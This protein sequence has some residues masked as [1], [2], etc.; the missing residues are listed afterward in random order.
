M[1]EWHII[2]CEYPPQVGGVS[3]YTYMLASALAAAGDRLHMWC[4]AGSG[5]PPP[6]PGLIV[7]RELGE[8]TP[9]DLHRVGKKLDEFSAPRR[10]LVQ[11]VPHGYGYQSMNLYFCT[12]LWSRVALHHDRVEIMVHEPFLPFSRESLKQTAAAVVHRVMTLVLLH[13]ACRVWV[14]IPAWEVCLRPYALGR[15]LTWAWLPVP[16]SVPEVAD[17][18]GVA[19]VRAAHAPPQ[20]FLVGHFGAYAGS[21][22]ELL[23]AFVAEL[24]RRNPAGAVLLLGRGSVAQRDELLR[25][26]P[27]LAGQVHATGVLAAAD[28]SRHLRACDVLIQPYPD[29]VSS[30]RTSVMAGLSHGLPIVTTVGDLTEALWA[31]SGAV[32]L[33]PAGD[34]TTMVKLTERLLRDK[35][36][37]NRLTAAAKALHEHRFALGHTVATLRAPDG[38][39]QP[40]LRDIWRTVL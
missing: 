32:A 19:L 17:S 35:T 20:G 7:H 12:W 3:D 2:T 5:D 13:A 37:R 11:W 26:H 30:R 23:T 38:C 14:A 25:R 10:L 29:G 36:E 24:L 1:A 4:P 28:I 16:G 21:I 18:K 34:V 6:A 22:R 31:E 9:G 8:F 15:H 33:A 40:S 27:N 39:L